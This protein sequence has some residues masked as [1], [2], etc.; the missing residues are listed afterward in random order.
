MLQFFSRRHFNLALIIIVL[1]FIVLH[2]LSS[3]SGMDNSTWSNGAPLAQLIYELSV[4]TWLRSKILTIV[5][6]GLFIGF[7]ILLV[8]RITSLIKPLDKYSF[9]VAWIYLLTSYFFPEW[10]NLT[11]ALLAQTLL[12]VILYNFYKLN[13][14]QKDGFMFTLSTLLSIAFLFWYP[15]ILLLPFMFVL[16]FQY[17]ALSLRKIS[18]TL[19]SFSIP[20]IW[21]V[22][23]FYFTGQ[24]TVLINQWTSLHIYP[25]H[26]DAL[27]HLQ[28][29]PIGIVLAYIGFG[30]I[31]AWTLTNKTSKNARL[32][33]SSMFSLVFFLGLAFTLNSHQII[34][35]FQALLYPGALFIVLFINNFKRQRISEIA[36][37]ILLLSVLF[38][39]VF[40]NY[41]S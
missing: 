38:N 14:L 18:I 36:H 41:Y 19:L 35:S 34:Y 33:I 12:L 23:Y 24:T 25:P 20:V 30:M 16:L 27:H 3:P 21:C 10:S 2:A 37:I 13:D 6:S 11:P 40:Q 32:F 26:M 5:I 28:W 22:V 29:I 8:Y 1:F 9:L 4:E 31:E 17:N 7:Q 39:F 15:S